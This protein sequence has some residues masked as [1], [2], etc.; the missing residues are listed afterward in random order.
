[1][2]LTGEVWRSSATT[3]PASP[4]V[5]QVLTGAYV[6]DSGDIRL[7]GEPV[8]FRKPQDARDAGI[9]TVYQQLAVIPA[10]DIASNLY[11]G[12]ED[13]RK[14]PMGSVLRMLDKKGMEKRAGESV[15]D[16]GIQTIQN[17]GQRSRNIRGHVRPMPSPCAALG[18][19]SSSS[20]SHRCPRRQ[21]VGHGVEMVKQLVTRA[22]GHPHL[23]HNMPQVW[24]SRTA[25]IKRLGV[26]AG[27]IHP[28]DPRTWVGRRDNDRP[29]AQ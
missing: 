16:L 19:K 21:G 24:G 9:E 5:I 17:M 3:V 29:E 10:L 27:V 28:R 7:N 15:R 11:L 14:G 4:H 18:S 23:A 22:V 8:S 20:M 12:R 1:M 6:P 13:R 25:P 26:G 2:T